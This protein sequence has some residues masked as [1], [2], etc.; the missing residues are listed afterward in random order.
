[1]LEAE[2]EGE[3][4]EP[5]EPDREGR[6]LLV[7]AE[8]R[9]Q[10]EPGERSGAQREAGIDPDDGD[11]LRVVHVGAR[12]ERRGEP[13]GRLHRPLR[14]RP[15]DHPVPSLAELSEFVLQAVLAVLDPEVLGGEARQLAVHSHEQQEAPPATAQLPPRA[16]SD[17]LRT[18][19]PVRA[20]ISSIPPTIAASISSGP[21][22]WRSRSWRRW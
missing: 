17:S 9:A 21:A 5:G 14:E 12:S 3:G 10:A 1:M 20:F 2:P 6:R 13:R 11:P 4:V 22:R 19:A 8:R 7:E 15:R 16:P 18:P